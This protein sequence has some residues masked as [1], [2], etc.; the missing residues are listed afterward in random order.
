MP[1]A[2]RLRDAPRPGAILTALTEPAPIPDPYLAADLPNAAGPDALAEQK[3]S[4]TAI[5]AATLGVLGFVCLPLIGGVLGIALGIAAKG[6]IEQ[7]GGKRG[8]AGL[9]I[10]GIALGALNLL[11]G[12]AGLAGLL[13]ALFYAPS[14]ATAS[15]PSPPLLP[16]PVVAP[17]LPPMPTASTAPKPP[18]T[19]HGASHDTEILRTRVGSVSLVDL[20]RDVGS[21]TRALEAERAEAQKQNEKLLLWLVVPDCKPCNGVAAALPDPRMQKALGRVRLVRVDVRDFASDLSYLGVPTDKIPGFALLGATGRPTD[22]VHGGEWDEDVAR[23]IAPVLGNFVQG[24]YLK[25]RH[26]WTGVRRDDE[27]QL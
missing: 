6:E 23:N 8:G 11:A 12:A 10:T 21:L 2:A 15:S 22:Y 14:T 20:G 19:P 25:R 26:P 5:A 17:V 27:T 9:A 24:R 3:T 16:P 4:G 13:F 18:P 1:R 7:S